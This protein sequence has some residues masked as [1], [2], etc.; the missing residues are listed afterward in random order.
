VENS[1]DFF[2]HRDGQRLKARRHRNKEMHGNS[3]ITKGKDKMAK[4]VADQT[5]KY[6]G[7]SVRKASEFT[8]TLADTFED[9]LSTAKRAAQ[10]GRD[11]VEGLLHD[12]TRRVKRRP[13]ESILISLA[14]GVVFGFL[15][16]RATSGE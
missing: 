11:A 6:I 13:I 15:V 7:E 9:G 14:V 8:S 10:D 5:T 16:G 12:T 1:H 4:S 3:S 2:G